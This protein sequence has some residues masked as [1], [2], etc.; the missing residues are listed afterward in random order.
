MCTLYVIFTIFLQ[1]TSSFTFNHL[2]CINYNLHCFVSLQSSHICVTASPPKHQG[3]LPLLSEYR[4]TPLSC[5]NPAIN[6]AIA[7]LSFL[8][9]HSMYNSLPQA[10]FNSLYSVNELFSGNSANVF[11]R[12]ISLQLFFTNLNISLK[13]HSCCF[14][15]RNANPIL[16]SSSFTSIAQLFTPIVHFCHSE[17]CFN[18]VPVF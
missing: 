12:S 11:C 5:H 14:L 9:Q 6:H 10:K 7:F 2:S 1:A 17:N 8:E 15:H 18:L 16:C 4:P 3:H 13:L